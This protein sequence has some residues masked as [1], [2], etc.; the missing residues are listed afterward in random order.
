MVRVGET[1]RV[2]AMIRVAGTALLCLILA[3]AGGARL[4]GPASA[5]AELARSEPAGGALVSSAPARVDIWFTQE[6][7]RR[8]GENT[9]QVFD[10]TGQPVQAGEA[11]VE[12]DDRSHLYVLLPAGLV[13]GEYRVAWRSLSAED[14]DV[15]QGSFRFT[16]DPQAPAAA[17][18]AAAEPAEAPAQ[19]PSSAPPPA[20]RGGCPAGLLPLGSLAALAWRS[21]RRRLSLP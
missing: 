3:L 8:A 16:Y 13:P 9:I 19:A 10:P 1:T 4:W 12:D 2:A 7:F 6:L 18:T 20:G 17:A 11:Q 14:G 15:A 5:H 21:N